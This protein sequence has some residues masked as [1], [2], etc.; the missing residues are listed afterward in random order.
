MSHVQAITRR[1]H[2]DHIG[3]IIEACGLR[4]DST[5]IVAKLGWKSIVTRRRSWGLVKGVL[6]LESF[7]KA[8]LPILGL[9]LKV[10]TDFFVESIDLLWLSS[11]REL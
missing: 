11:R 6:H 4:L 2:A 1:S 5:F 10:G 8:M 3:T 7:L 9:N